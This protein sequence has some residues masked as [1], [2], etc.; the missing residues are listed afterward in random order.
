MS[1][2]D[3]KNQETREYGLSSHA[4]DDPKRNADQDL[5]GARRVT[6]E[7]GTGPEDSTLSDQI[8]NKL[9]VLNAEHPGYVKPMA[10]LDNR[11]RSLRIDLQDGEQFEKGVFVSHLRAI[12][13]IAKDNGLRIPY[14]EQTKLC[15]AFGLPT[16]IYSDNAPDMDELAEALIRVVEKSGENTPVLSTATKKYRG[17]D[18]SDIVSQDARSFVEREFTSSPSR[19]PRLDAAEDDGDEDI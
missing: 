7:D 14:Q 5:L 15:Q 6:E 17:G 11:T 16:N 3:V 8:Q 12:V 1:Y 19:S 2:N 4:Y 9:N 13:S 18:S 10:E